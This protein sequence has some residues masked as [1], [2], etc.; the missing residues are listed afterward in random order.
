MILSHKH[1][2]LFIKGR[3]VG[4]TSIE[5]LLAPFCGPSDIVTPISPVDEIRRL[6]AG[7][8]PRNYCP[9]P[10]VE[11]RYLQLV[12][13]GSFDEA[14]I[15]RVHSDKVYP[16]FNHMSVALV[17]QLANF[18]PSEFTLAYVVRNPYAKIISLANMNLSFSGYSGVP[19][20]NNAADIRRSIQKL[21]ETDQ[22]LLARNIYLYQTKMA[23][24][25][26]IILR[27]EHM[28]RDIR[29]FLN[30]LGLEQIGVE[31][32]YAKQGSIRK[33]Y[34]ARTMFTREQLD[35]VNST[36][37]DEFNNKDLCITSG[38]PRVGRFGKLAGKSLG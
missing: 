13:D 25:H 37:A 17:E 4:G 10:A 28:V 18:V 12:R 8:A 6:N 24:Q 29:H 22:F 9:D 27:Q 21:F 31:I 23:Y 14:R 36:F 35:I 33:K 30:H 19:M 20:E 32:P 1:S 11:A 2:F 15:M 38:F 26:Q 16:F 5:M 7:G 34:S 3:K